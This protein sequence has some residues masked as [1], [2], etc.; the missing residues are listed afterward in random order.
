MA[1]CI[2]CGNEVEWANIAQSTICSQVDMFGADSLT[3][4]EQVVY[5]GKCC[6]DCID[7]LN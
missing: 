2:V 7:E 3:E 6:I 4:H 1:K 5:E